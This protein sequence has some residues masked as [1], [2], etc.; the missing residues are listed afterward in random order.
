MPDIAAVRSGLF[1]TISQNVTGLT[2]ASN[3]FRYAPSNPP[4]TF[5]FCFFQMREGRVTRGGESDSP[6]RFAGMRETQHR[7][8]FTMCFSLQT[9]L[10]DAEKNAEPFVSR[11]ISAIDLHKTLAGSGN[12]ADAAVETYEVVEVKLRPDQPSY[13]GIRF[14]I[15]VEEI[16]EGTLVGP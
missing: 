8:N 10:A 9:D 2:A 13:Y 5:P 4:D 11:V 6:A 1:T 3:V 12:V 16:E 7:V 15:W 14:V